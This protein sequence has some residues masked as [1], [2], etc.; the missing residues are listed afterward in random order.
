MISSHPMQ[1]RSWLK[2]SGCGFGWLAFSALISESYAKDQQPT[3]PLGTAK[4]V[5]FLNM[6]GGPSHV[7]TFDYKP[8][9]ELA[10]GKPGPRPGS[11]W[12]KSPWRFHQ[13][14]ESGLWISELL[15]ELSSIAD[16]LLLVNSMQTEVPA[17]PQASIRMHTGTSQFVRPSLGSWVLY[18]LG[19]GNDNLP[20][21]ISIAGGGVG[22]LRR[23]AD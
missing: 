8:E 7:D 15:P 14:G 12:M 19:S 5:I 11:K 22:G 17:H 6:K 4:R 18:G 3:L 13:R 16:E 23:I 1:R 2:S 20:G 9:L 10:D 21:F